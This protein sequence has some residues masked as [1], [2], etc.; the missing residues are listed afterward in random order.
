MN[1]RMVLHRLEI[2]CTLQVSIINKIDKNEEGFL[3]IVS[4]ILLSLTISLSF[5]PTQGHRNV[6]GKR[7]LHI[8]SSSSSF[9]FPDICV[10]PGA[11][12]S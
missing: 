8:L 12:S 4:L 2:F 10:S 9:W 7:Y 5:L 11:V 6:P 1:F 3:L